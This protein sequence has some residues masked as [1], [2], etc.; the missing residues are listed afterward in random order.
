MITVLL[1]L[2]SGWRPVYSLDHV[3]PLA[4]MLRKYVK[5]PLRIEL[6]TDFKLD[7]AV[8]K[9]EV[10]RVRP[11]PEVSVKLPTHV[12]DCFRRLR[13]HDPEYQQQFE[14]QWLLSL[15]LDTLVT[16]DITDDLQWAIDSGFG[17]AVQRA[18]K[19][20]PGLRPYAGALQL[21]ERGK[22]EHVWR[23]LF[24]EDA[25]GRIRRSG[26]I[27]SDQVWLSLTLPGA[28]T[29][30]PEHGFVHFADRHDWTVEPKVVHFGHGA[31]P[32]KNL[33]LDLM[34][35]YESFL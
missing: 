32:W 24:R 4:R 15:D 8:A 11:L 27:G 23:E 20:G 3:R 19:V 10:D 21:I 31:K 16:D 12:A 28:P 18:M 14:T 5:Q 7:R 35:A 33:S 1:C 13:F 9:L 25:H 2:W 22:T 6:L 30:G 29:F 17:F 26:W 34:K